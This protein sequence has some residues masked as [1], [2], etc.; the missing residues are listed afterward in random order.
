MSPVQVRDALPLP[1]L[2]KRLLRNKTLTVSGDIPVEQGAL[3]LRKLRPLKVRVKADPRTG[4][5][6]R[7]VSSAL[8]AGR[9]GCGLFCQRSGPECT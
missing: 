6:N 3:H 7:V 5:L 4:V 9:A 8:S 1:R 2:V